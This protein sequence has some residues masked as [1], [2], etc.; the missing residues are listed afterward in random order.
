M[1]CDP[2]LGTHIAEHVST[3]FKQYQFYITY[4]P[5]FWTVLVDLKEVNTKLL[6][7]KHYLWK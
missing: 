4:K 3:T 7:Y 5:Y 6:I 2:K 1:A